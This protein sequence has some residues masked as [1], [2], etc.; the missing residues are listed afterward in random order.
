[1]AG[2]PRIWT[3]FARISWA[4]EYQHTDDGWIR[5]RSRNLLHEHGPEFRVVLRVYG[6]ERRIWFPKGEL[7]AL[8]FFGEPPRHECVICGNGPSYQVLHL[9]GNRRD[10]SRGNLKYVPDHDK[11]RW[12]ELKCCEMIMQRRPHDPRRRLTLDN[13]MFFASDEDISLF[14]RGSPFK[15]RPSRPAFCPA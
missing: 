7:L 3:P 11:A 8:E 14:A 15:L 13:R 1:M 4:A 6:T 5:D 2:A 10:C 12:H 9:N